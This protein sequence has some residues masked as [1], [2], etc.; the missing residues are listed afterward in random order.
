MFHISLQ[1]FSC[2]FLI[3]SLAADF[4]DDEVAAI[5]ME[6]SFA[7]EATSLEA[8]VRPDIPIQRLEKHVLPGSLSK[9]VVDNCCYSVFS[10]PLVPVGFIAYHDSQFGFLFA[11]IA[12]EQA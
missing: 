2:G 4:H 9:Y 8:L 7:D 1:K 5:V 6:R 11:I 3:L 10:V 12:V